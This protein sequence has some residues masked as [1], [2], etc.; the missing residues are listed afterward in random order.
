V[1]ILK[2]LFANEEFELYREQTAEESIRTENEA[3]EE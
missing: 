2:V 1:E 3:V